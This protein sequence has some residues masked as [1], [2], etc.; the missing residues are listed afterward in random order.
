MSDVHFAFFKLLT[1]LR[2]EPSLYST[3]LPK[4]RTWAAACHSAGGL[5]TTWKS[6]GFM[7]FNMKV[8][9][10]LSHYIIY[11]VMLC[12]WF[13]ILFCFY[14]KC[15]F[16]PGQTQEEFVKFFWKTPL[17][18]YIAK[19]DPEMQ[20]EFFQ[21]YL[22][23]FISMTMNVTSP[24]DLQVFCFV[25]ILFFIWCWRDCVWQYI[26]MHVIY[27]S[28]SCVVLWILVLTNCGCSSVTLKRWRLF[29][30]SMLHIMNSKTGSRTSAEW[31]ALYLSWPKT[32]WWILMPETGLNW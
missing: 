5:R 12:F 23:D 26:L 20:V 18:R 1:V 32:S 14:I 8:V 30:G 29:R 22:Q 15:I 3:T 4:I 2:R 28:S 24:E 21:R 31:C 17:G 7:H 6:S 27:F 10:C 25:F 13:V 19:A 9:V 16:L 11:I